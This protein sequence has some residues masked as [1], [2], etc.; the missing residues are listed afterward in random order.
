MLSVNICIYTCEKERNEYAKE[1]RERKT[2]SFKTSFTPFWIFIYVFQLLKLKT[3][4]KWE[5]RWKNKNN[6]A[7]KLFFIMCTTT[8]RW[9]KCLVWN[10]SI[11]DYGWNEVG[12]MQSVWDVVCEI[13][14]KL[15]L[16]S[17]CFMFLKLF[18]KPK[19]CGIWF[20]IIKLKC[21]NL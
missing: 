14:K 10:A 1:K 2:K 17:D 8:M 15:D 19:K 18:K 4:I 11:Y 13:E 5:K 7:I 12:Y 3:K 16:Y 21:V 6:N 20:W 9:D